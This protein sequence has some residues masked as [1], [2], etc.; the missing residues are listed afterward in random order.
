MSDFIIIGQFFALIGA[1]MFFAARRGLFALKFFQQQEYKNGKFIKFIFHQM[2]LVDKIASV[3][4]VILMAATWQTGAMGWAGA[5]VFLAAG[6]REKNPFRTAKKKLVFTARAQRIYF[7]AMAL[8]LLIA[9][10]AGFFAFLWTIESWMVWK[11]SVFVPTLIMMVFL[12]NLPPFVII[13]SNM[14]LF[15]F[16]WMLR[17]K[18]AAEAQQKLRE[19]NP[20]CIGITGSFGKTSTKNICAHIMKSAGLSTYATARSIN[21]LMGVS[22]VIREELKPSHKY[23]IV[24]MG[25]DHP[26]GIPALCKLIAP[27]FGILTAVGAAHYENFGSA[28]AIAVEKFSLP[29]A[30]HDN[31]GKC[32]I[33]AAQIAREFIEN[34]A[35]ADAVILPADAVKN[36]TVRADGLHFHFRGREIFAPVYGTHAANNIALAITTAE[37]L[38]VPMDT[39][40]AALKS[41]PQTEHRLEVR[42]MGKMTLIDDGFNSNIDGF[43]SAVDTLRILADAH[44]GRAI[45]ITPGMVELGAKHDE[46]HKTAGAR[47]NERADIVIAVA[48]D[49]IPTFT[50]EIDPKKLIRVANKAA[51]DKWLSENAA[52]ND[53]VLYENDLPDLF[54]EK[55]II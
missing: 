17:R 32:V 50:A 13:V 29:R 12:A 8:V 55:I 30:I 18:Y 19:L 51:A 14:I 28:D 16:E 25:T 23:F 47:T 31:G 5:L 44:H 2:Q 40:V 45:I 15:P 39:I 36:V 52:P 21:T 46:Y 10:V 41:L 38:G 33:N 49:R 20:V 9:L 53:V 1:Y 4:A 35:P 37:I 34:Y 7:I 22:R 6:I 42:Q 27:R 3:A 11:F 26:G 48:S 43:L 24:E 54:E